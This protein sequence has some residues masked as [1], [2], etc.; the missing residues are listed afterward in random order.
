[1]PTSYPGGLDS[2]SN[3]TS[4]TAMN[5]AAFQHD[6]L[7]SNHNDAIEQIEAEL[8]TNPKGSFAS[9]KARLN[10][11]DNTL[12]QNFARAPMITVASSEMSA[13]VQAAC[14]YSCNGTNDQTQINNALKQAS[15]IN[16][17]FA[18][19]EGWI[20]V[21]LVGGT[22]HI[23]ANGTPIQMY[24][25]T[26]LSGYG[27]GTL[28]YPKFTAGYTGGCI[29]QINA[30]LHGAVVRDLSIANPGSGGVV[31][32]GSGIKWVLNDT[33][34]TYEIGSANDNY[35]RI[36]NVT[37]IKPQKKGIHCNGGR[38]VQ[39]S[40]STFINTIEEGVLLENHSDAKVIYCVA[41]GTDG[42]A[43]GFSLA[44]GNIKI[45]DCKV[46]YRGNKASGGSAQHGFSITGSRASVSNCEAQD[47]G[48]WGF[49]VTS[50]DVTMSGCSADSNSAQSGSMG[51]FFISSQGVYSGLN[52]FDRNQSTLRQMT[53][54]SFSGSPNV[55]V[56]GRA[57]VPSGSN[58]VVGS[59]GSNS[60]AR[61]VREGTTVFSAG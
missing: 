2:W 56:T 45:G 33:G 47:N 57:S 29:E 12:A 10:D 28:L 6:V 44:S 4:T 22:F 1:V 21:Q 41:T 19:G 61:I 35:N 54:I 8:G 27:R 9:V 46:F 14:D 3:P 11:I 59:V 51:G 43:P 37:V 48:G 24:P 16:D 18:G 17:G 31:F 26:T 23:G 52:A 25:N 40:H 36:Q 55:Y 32:P 15:R 7:H 34:S 53:G 58:Q 20:G 60:Y 42:T 38:E 49:Y 39:I 30:N 5:D 13:S 50:T